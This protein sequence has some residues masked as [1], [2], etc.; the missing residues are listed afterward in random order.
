MDTTRVP[1][2]CSCMPSSFVPI[3]FEKAFG[4]AG[5][6]YT[7]DYLLLCGPYSNYTMED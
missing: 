1:R 3:A 2:R 4:A 6:L 7:F 5:A